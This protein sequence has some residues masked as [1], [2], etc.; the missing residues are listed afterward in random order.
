MGAI[1]LL[2]LARVL[3][4]RRTAAR[5][6]ALL[7]IWLMLQVLSLQHY[8]YS[9]RQ[10]ADKITVLLFYV[11]ALPCPPAVSFPLL[12]STPAAPI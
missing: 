7:T 4:D 9:S 2:R 10:V 1:L 8:Y 6:V 12:V 11:L 5:I 3:P